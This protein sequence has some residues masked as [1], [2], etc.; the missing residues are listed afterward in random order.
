ME[1]PFALKFRQ[2][3]QKNMKKSRFSYTKRGLKVFHP[4]NKTYTVLKHLKCE[5]KLVNAYYFVLRGRSVILLRHLYVIFVI[6]F[7]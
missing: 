7:F 2:R 5:Q 6:T 4:D 1:L 3:V